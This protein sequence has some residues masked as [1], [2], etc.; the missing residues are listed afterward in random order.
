MCG[1]KCK[2]HRH[3]M[4]NMKIMLCVVSTAHVHY[5]FRLYEVSVFVYL[6]E[7]VKIKCVCVCVL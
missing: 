2:H 7:I 3:V 4:C 1:T 6:T 5:G